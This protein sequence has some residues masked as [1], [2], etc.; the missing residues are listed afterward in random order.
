MRSWLKFIN[1]IP[2]LPGYMR[3][4]S[5]LELVLALKVTFYNYIRFRIDLFVLQHSIVY[6]CDA[7]QLFEMDYPGTFSLSNC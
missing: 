3:T 1:S 4:S 6:C 7:F 2:Q 5:K